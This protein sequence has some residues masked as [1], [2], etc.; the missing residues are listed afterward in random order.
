MAKIVN[1]WNDW[2]P[3]KHVIVGVC[4]RTA[5]KDFVTTEVEPIRDAAD[6]MRMGKDLFIRHG[7]TTNRTAIPT[8]ASATSTRPTAGRSSTPFCAQEQ[9]L[10]A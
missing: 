6:V 4:V 8:R 1:S 2:G 7:L 3:L 9:W 10:K 5:N